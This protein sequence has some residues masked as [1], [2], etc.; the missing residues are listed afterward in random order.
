MFLYA[1]RNCVNCVGCVN[2]RNQ[3]YC[4]FNKRYIKEEYLI[5]EIW[6]E[7]SEVNKAIIGTNYIFEQI[8]ED[9]TPSLKI[10]Y[11]RC[12]FKNNVKKLL[13]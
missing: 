12:G 8:I 3:E 13:K 4:I 5:D 2:L 10:T 11:K 9:K 7:D 1:C 6:I